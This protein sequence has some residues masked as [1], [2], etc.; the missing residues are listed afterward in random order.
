MYTKEEEKKKA[1]GPSA[2]I[3]HPSC[4]FFSKII[5]KFCHVCFKVGSC[6]GRTDR[7]Q[8]PPVLDIF[9]TILNTPYPKK[10]QKR[11]EKKILLL[12]FRLCTL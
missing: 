9:S 7:V 5:T 8:K 10:I 11:K 6:E 4:Q 12:F 2:F 1:E 3:W